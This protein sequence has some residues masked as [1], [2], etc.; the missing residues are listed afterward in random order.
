MYHDRDLYLRR[1]GEK[2]IQPLHFQCL[3]T[4]QMAQF[5]RHNTRTPAEGKDELSKLF[6]TDLRME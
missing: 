5:K 3:K 1:Y 2:K 4:L 6:S